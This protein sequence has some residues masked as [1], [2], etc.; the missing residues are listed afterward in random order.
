M[1]SILFPTEIDFYIDTI[2]Y[3]NL[4]DLGNSNWL[5][6]HERLQKLNQE[7]VIEASAMKEEYVKEAFVT[8]NKSSALVHE[9]ILVSI[10]K[11]KLLPLLLQMRPDPES[12]FIAYSIL[13]HEAVAVSLLELIL[14][15]P[16]GCES[17]G[18]AASD[19]LEY[20]YDCVAQLLVIECKEPSTAE[21][22]RTEILRQKE[23]LAF[24]I[25]IRCLSIIRYLAENMDRIAIGITSRIYST[26]DVPVLLVQVMLHKP[27][28]SKGKVYREGSWV[29]NN[30]PSDLLMQSEAQI[31]LSLRQL[32]L[33]K[34]CFEYYPIT[35]S[36]RSQLMKLMPL[37]SP[38][39]LDQLSPLMELNHW[40][41]QLSVTELPSSNNK[42][43]LLE[44]ILEIKNN[45]LKQGEKKWK[46]IAK[47]QVDVIF[48]SDKE[49]LK[50]TAQRLMAAYNTDL[51]EKMETKNKEHCTL[52]DKAAIQRCSKCKKTWYCSRNCQVSDW[53]THKVMCIQ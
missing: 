4:K 1:D 34:A 24:S 11:Q 33:D 26:L 5:E 43:F 42:P 7:A 36:R 17:L 32:L 19:L 9:A 8:L 3:H 53:N 20:A 16:N 52:C 30:L 35:D 25:G 21:K 22:G 31:W 44:T 14:F 50:T 39:L 51:L 37:L 29:E 27:W 6:W 47:D 15:H 48:C 2:K 49:V 12:T 13:Y 45:I 38:T 28:I 10:W 46:K 23:D 18:D 41:C 40:L